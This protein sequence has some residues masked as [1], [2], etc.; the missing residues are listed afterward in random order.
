MI[1]VEN[2]I[3]SYRHS[4]PVLRDVSFN[5]ERGESLCVLGPNGTGKT[6][7]FRC[8]LNL[9]SIQGGKIFIDGKDA[10]SLRP[11]VRARLIS[12]VPQASALTFSY[13]AWETVLMGRV[14]HQK[15]G[16]SVSLKDRIAAE[17]AMERLNVLCMAQCRFHELSGGERQL[18]LIARALAQETDCLILDE[19]TAS[20]DYANQIRI[21][22]VIRQLAEDGYAI[23]MT[24]HL[25]DQAF[26]A[27]TRV[28]MLK[29]G[30]VFADGTP[31]DIITSRNLSSLYG[32]DVYVADAQAVFNSGT[33]ES[34]VCIPSMS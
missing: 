5:F 12:Y 27:A 31:E 26:L 8:L 23:L 1:R 25:P 16:A 3:F 24:S 20:L 9:H 29:D 32:L 7:L 18:V 2:V 6:T 13:T 14:A 17:A 30:I 10:A 22:Q 28:L 19:P 33:Q 34:K 4:A 21:L 15:L 11:R